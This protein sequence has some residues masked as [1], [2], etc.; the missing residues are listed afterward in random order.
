MCN[1]TST[2]KMHQRERVYGLKDSHL[3]TLPDRLL[4]EW[5]NIAD[6]LWNAGLTKQIQDRIVL[7]PVKTDGKKDPELIRELPTQWQ[8]SGDDPVT[9]EELRDRILARYDIEEFCDVM[10]IDLEEV[11]DMFMDRVYNNIKSLDIN[12]PEIDDGTEPNC[13]EPEDTEVPE[14]GDT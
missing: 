4:V 7:V 12:A 6:D 2:E 1:P 13:S 10:E 8:D 5:L 9:E 11:L 14:E 3:S